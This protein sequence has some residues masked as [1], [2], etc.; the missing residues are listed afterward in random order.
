MGIVFSVP[1]HLPCSSPWSGG[2]FLISGRTGW[3]TDCRE[4]RCLP[5]SSTFPLPFPLVISWVITQDCVTQDMLHLQLVRSI[6][7]FH[8][9]LKR[10]VLATGFDLQLNGKSYSI[11]PGPQE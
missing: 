8:L 1:A 2:S 3:V 4:Q 5:L 6:T 11:F 10:E 7:S 9:S